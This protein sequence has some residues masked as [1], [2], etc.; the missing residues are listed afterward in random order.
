MWKFYKLIASL[1]SGTYFL[2]RAY[3]TL[4]YKKNTDAL[5]SIL[6]SWNHPWKISST[7]HYAYKLQATCRRE[8]DS[9]SSTEDYPCWWGLPHWTRFINNLTVSSSRIPSS[10]AI[11]IP[12]AESVVSDS[13]YFKRRRLQRMDPG[14]WRMRTRRWGPGQDADGNEQSGRV[15]LCCCC[16]FWRW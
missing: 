15:G 9:H 12:S 13:G 7:L 14:G 8:S 4:F 6:I 16:C 3:G 2:S 1:S 5:F 10:S 11:M